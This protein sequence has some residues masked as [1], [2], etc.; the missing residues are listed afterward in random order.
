MTE[1]ISPPTDWKFRLSL[2]ASDL[3]SKLSSS[4]HRLLSIKSYLDGTSRIYSGVSVKDEGLGGGWDGHITPQDL[5]TTLGKK[6]R[7]TALDCFEEGRTMFCA[8]AWVENNA[9]VKWNWT[10]DKTP[11]K[12]NAKLQKEEGKLISIRAYKTTIGGTLTTAAIRYCAIWVKDDG[13]VEWD[14]IP[15]T[16]EDSISDTLDAESAQLISIDNLDNETWLGDGEH[17]CAV[18]YRN[19]T[20]QVSFWNIG[21][22]K[23]ELPK[24]PPKFCSWGFDVSYCSKN[25]FVSV[26]EQFPKP[27]DPNLASLMTMSG[28][29]D[30]TLN[31]DL[32]QNITWNLSEQNLVSE[33]VDLESAFMFTVEEGGWSWWSANFPNPSGPTLFGLP[34]SLAASQAYNSTPIWNKPGKV[35]VFLLEAVSSGGKHQFLLSQAVI[36]QAGF[37]TPPTLPIKWPVFLGIQA[38]VEIIK[39]T[40]GKYWGT[41]AGQVINGTGRK[42]DITNVKV[43]L[44]DQNNVTVHKSYFT[45]KMRIEQDVLGQEIKPPLDGPVSDSDAPLPKFYDGFEVPRT[46][47]KGTL[48]V[49]ANVK[50]R[51]GNLECYGDERTLT[52]GCVTGTVMDRLPV[53]VP[54]INGVYDPSYRWHWDNG[55]GGTSF[56]VHSSPWERYHY[57]VAVRNPSNKTYTGDPGEN[58]NYYCWG[59]PVFSM[60]SGTVTFVTNGYEDNNGNKQDKLGNSNIVVIRNDAGWYHVYAH[61]QQDTILVEP[62]KPGDPPVVVVPGQQLGV[63]GNSGGSSEPHLHVGIR[64]RDIHGFI[65][66]LPMKFQKVKNG[67]GKTVSGVLA[68]DDFYD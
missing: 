41:V 23:T 58:G 54:V 51:D 52:V 57:D 7:L 25:R 5:T 48:K 18:W 46:F 20:G 56:N 68:T 42:L 61:F 35:G 16:V 49:Q 19:V 45:K 67:A 30:A 34:L 37:P 6:F 44:T 1:L 32:T 65:R 53:D 15:D 22:S 13:I 26:M 28:S 39:L 27:D 29:A 14:W 38:P 36:T 33:Q 12:L 24:E 40:N 31:D 55:L 11:S 17:F 21:L 10:W 9:G 50:F 66:S 47:T 8:A 43:I 63:V 62:A 3:S 4:Q 64:G 2:S 59:Q 60:S